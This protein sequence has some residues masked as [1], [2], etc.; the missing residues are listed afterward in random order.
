VWCRDTVV[1]WQ[2]LKKLIR[3]DEMRLEEQ[4]DQERKLREITKKKLAAA[5]AMEKSGGLVVK[6]ESPPPEKQVTSSC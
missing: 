3:D 6:E 2:D 1:C 4:T 5:K